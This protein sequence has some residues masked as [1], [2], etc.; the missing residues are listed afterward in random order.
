VL[1]GA[2]FYGFGVPEGGALGGVLLFLL[3][4]MLVLGLFGVSRAGFV[5]VPTFVALGLG[6]M[7][8]FYLPFGAF[9]GGG[10]A[11]FVAF[12]LMLVQW[13]RVFFQR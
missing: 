7:Y 5:L 11:G 8:L 3:P 2:V 10:G 9:T 4:L 1:I 13:W 12:V 6:I